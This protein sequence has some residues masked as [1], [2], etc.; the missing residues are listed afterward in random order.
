MAAVAVELRRSKPAVYSPIRHL[1]W[2]LWLNHN[3]A[4]CYLAVATT[5]AGFFDASGKPQDPVLYVSGF[6]S[7]EK[8]WLRF[9]KEWQ[10]LLTR[11]EI[12]GLFHTSDYVRGAGEDYRQFLNN[13]A[14]RIEFEGKAVSVIKR[15]T[16]KPFSYGII[17]EDHKAIVARYELPYG[18]E[19]P[20]SFCGLQGV[21][22]IMLW[23]GKKKG[24]SL[25]DKLHL[26]YEDGDEDRGRF[27]DAM[28]RDFR[29]RPNFLPK[30][31]VHPFAAADI[32]A[33]RHNRLIREHK[34]KTPRPPR[35]FFGA[36]FKQIPHGPS[37]GFYDYK[38]LE[39]FC[40]EKRFARR[41]RPTTD[42][43]GVSD[44]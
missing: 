19:R 31:K 6:V 7:T 16:L 1:A 25:Q 41:D 36:L 13:E 3:P 30:D 42:V 5:Y 44:A 35:E 33:W 28:H 18:F 39:A 2:A 21:Y 27:S 4:R 10:A 38:T 8:K 11:F 24:T 34:A 9:E 23:L 22:W 15:N 12:R 32:L 14:R 26:I 29:R 43:S 40:E 17:L 37:C 20:Y